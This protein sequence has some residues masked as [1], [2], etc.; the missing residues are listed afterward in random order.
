MKRL[1]CSAEALIVAVIFALSA[2]EKK[3]VQTEEAKPATS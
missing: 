3:T 2:C 1:A